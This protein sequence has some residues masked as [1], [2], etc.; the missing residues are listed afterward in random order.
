MLSNAT[1]ALN[2]VSSFIGLSKFNW[3]SLDIIAVNTVAD[4]HETVDDLPVDK[5]VVAKLQAFYENHDHTY[6]DHV[7][8]HGF[9]GCRPSM[10]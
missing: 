9:W 4:V 3:K 5:D 2:I 10:E 7:T 6:L 1:R 8:Q